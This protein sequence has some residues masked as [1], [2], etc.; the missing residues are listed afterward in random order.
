MFKKLLF[1]K[2]KATDEVISPKA[3][4]TFVKEHKLTWMTVMQT[5]LTLWVVVFLIFIHPSPKILSKHIVIMCFISMWI[6]VLL[7]L[8]KKFFTRGVAIVITAILILFYFSSGSGIE[9][10]LL[11]NIYVD[12]ATKYLNVAYMENGENTMGISPSGLVRKAMIDTLMKGGVATKNMQYIRDAI[13]IW[14]DDYK[15]ENIYNNKKQ[16][17][18]DVLWF[19]D[20]SKV[21]TS[22]LLQGDIL[23]YD[24]YLRIYI[25]IGNDIWIESNPSIGKVVAEIIPMPPERPITLYGKIVRWKVLEN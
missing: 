8:W 20:L 22:N 19:D 17:F 1:N 7:K 13:D 21:N 25:Y 14:I 16:L 23:V 11:R 15:I 2:K 3:E 18:T 24:D 9:S 6:I 4:I 12:N 5:I 10:E